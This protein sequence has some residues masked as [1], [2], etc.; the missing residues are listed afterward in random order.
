[1]NLLRLAAVSAFLLAAC[2]PAEDKTP[3]GRDEAPVPVTVSIVS[4]VD[5]APELVVSG[6]VKPAR[7]AVVSTRTSGEVTAVSVEAGDAVEA[8]QALL[9][10]DPRELESALAAAREGVDAAEAAL[11][12]AQK[13]AERMSRLHAE[14]LVARTRMEQAEL[15]AEQRQSELSRARAELRSRQVTLEYAR[16]AAPFAGT[17][18]EVMVD[19][20][21][22]AGPGTPLAVVEDRTRLEVD[23]S[24]AQ[25][26]ARGLVPGETV[27]VVLP[28]TDVREAGRIVAIIPALEGTGAGNRIRVAVDRSA[29]AF[30]PGQVVDIVLPR[31]G[32]ATVASLPADAVIR[33]GQL[34]GVFV[35]EDR[36]G[37]S[38]ARLR[39]IDTLASPEKATVLARGLDAGDRVVT[40]E[41]VAALRDGQPVRIET[42]L[43]G[44]PGSP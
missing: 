40:G 25:S 14:D 30:T 26:T 41:A 34:T 44:P 24:L 18:A 37:G 1:M 17:V 10:I 15:L 32:E 7:R 31:S 5:H 4:L 12:K 22:F 23:A 39:W 33:R 13:D 27:A 11:A 20:G 19:E 21:T 9:A 28:G 16:I 8:G 29:R 2:G 36:D 42:T 6:V 35:V 3:A 43:R 38:L